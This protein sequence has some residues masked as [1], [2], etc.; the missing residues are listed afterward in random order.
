MSLSIDLKTGTIHF[1]SA[2]DLR[3]LARMSN[4]A[5]VYAVECGNDTADKDYKRFGRVARHAVHESY[6]TP[7][8]SE[9]TPGFWDA[10]KAAP[11]AD[12]S[13]VFEEAA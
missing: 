10:L 6:T 2:D 12:A 7:I 13:L 11:P 3:F 9:Y 8:G 1:D 4:A 5:A